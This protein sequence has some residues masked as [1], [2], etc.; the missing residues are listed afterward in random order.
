MTHHTDPDHQIIKAPWTYE[1]VGLEY[2]RDLNLD[3]EPYIDLTL[4]REGIIRKLRFLGPNGLEIRGGFPFSAGLSIVDIS[5][6]QMDG[7]NVQV[8]NFENCDGCPEFF[9]RDVI[10]LDQCE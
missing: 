2:R 10:D 1:I 8:C 3:F 4:E 6:R 9:A 5:T 7:I